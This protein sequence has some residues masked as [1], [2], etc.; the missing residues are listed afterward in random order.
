MRVAAVA[1]AVAVSLG[2]VVWYRSG[3]LGKGWAARSGTPAALLAR[4]TA[5]Q[6]AARPI[7]SVRPDPASGSFTARLD[8]TV[9]EAP[10]ATGLVTV[11]VRGTL[12]GGR[13]GA[14]RLVLR[15]T[16]VDGGGVSMTASG[17]SLSR[18]GR[19]YTGSIVGLAG[20]RVAARLRD[21]SGRTLALDLVVLADPQG[22]V[23]GTAR[24]EIV[25]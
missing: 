16:P 17:V 20:P 2:L 6:P 24:G 15:G 4:S 9:S 22:H 1:A 11:S 23:R 7:A 3:P 12:D 13:A 5:A 18:G 10:A 21:A 25:G 19:I 8:G 14:L